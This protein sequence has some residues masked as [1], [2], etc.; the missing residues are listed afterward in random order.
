MTEKGWHELKKINK[1]KDLAEFRELKHLIVLKEISDM[2]VNWAKVNFNFVGKVFKKHFGP[3]G[4]TIKSAEDIKNFKFSNLKGKLSSLKTF[5][6][7]ILHAISIRP[8]LHKD[9]L[10][11]HEIK[12]GDRINFPRHG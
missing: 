9:G 6:E 5:R 11:M 7:D 2:D 1:L 8:I 4:D 10:T 12:P 3:V